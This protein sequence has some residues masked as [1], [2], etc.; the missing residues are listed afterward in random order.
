MQ[1]RLARLE[2]V[3]ALV[4]LARTVDG[5]MTTMPRD[6]DAMRERVQWSLDSVAAPVQV[7][8]NEMYLFV[9]EEEGEIVGLSAIFA[10][11]GLDRP[12]YSYR[13]SRISK[14]APEYDIQVSADILHL[15][16]DYGGTAELG[17]LF[18]RPDRRGGGRG[19]LL[20]YARLMFMACHRNR[21][22]ERLFAEI[23]GETDEKDGSPFWDA[24]GRRFF[25]LD[26]GEADKMSGRDYRFIADLMP[27]HPIYV[28]LLPEA[29][30][31]V[32]GKVNDGARGAA[33]LLEKQGLR[34]NGLVDIFDAG[35][36]LDA[37]TEDVKIVK[38]SQVLTV[39][40]NTGAAAG[41]PAMV[42]NPSLQDFR[43]VITETDIAADGEVRLPAQALQS[44]GLESGTSASVYLF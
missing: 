41:T 5:H 42:A 32:I 33:K 44:L 13:V 25:K 4:A 23:R 31:E 6:A 39:A 11:V 14:K 26:F 21:F 17:T 28:D 20:S 19:R 9:L 15:V 43:V 12:F 8:G 30:Q 3:D 2:D 16:N 1:V 29:A 7:P 38:K 37:R 10:A 40:E 35:A 22:P 34:Y 24:V 18:L 27:T 36:C